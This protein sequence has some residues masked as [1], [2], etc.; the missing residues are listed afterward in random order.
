MVI[1]MNEKQ[2]LTLA[3]LRSFLGT[4]AIDFAVAPEERYAFIA[5]TVRRFGYAVEAGGQVTLANQQ[6]LGE[7]CGG[8]ITSSPTN[9]AIVVN[10]GAL[11]RKI[12]MNSTFS[13]HRRSIERLE[14]TTRP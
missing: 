5:R 4:V 3:Q 13:R 6:H 10:C 7:D 12:A 8:F 14:I 2:L 1:D 9:L 11:S